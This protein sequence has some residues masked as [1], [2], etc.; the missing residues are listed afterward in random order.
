MRAPAAGGEHDSAPAREMLS[1]SAPL[2]PVD[3]LGGILSALTVVALILGIN[4][5]PDPD[6][7]TRVI[8]SRA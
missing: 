7:S 3:N 1:A 6:K 5:L 4:L 8:S 2:D